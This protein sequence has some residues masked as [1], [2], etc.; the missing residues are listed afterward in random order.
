MPSAPTERPAAA[1]PPPA[2]RAPAAPFDTHA[3]LRFVVN[4]MSGRND[5][6]AKQEVI[7]NAL[8]EAGRAGELLLAPPAE[9]ARVA[10]RA[11]AAAAADGGAVV[12]VGGDGTINAVAQAAHA[13][14]CAM[15]VLPQGTFNYFARTHGIPSDPAEAARA[16]FGWRPQPVQLGLVNGHRFLV[17][18][19]LGLYPE[20]L[21]DREAW[22]ARFGRSRIVAL[23]AAIATVVGARRRLRL[24]IDAGGRA[25]EVRT[26]TLFV[27]NNRLQLEQ[28][29]LAQAPALDAGH[30][31]AVT[32]RPIGT[33]AMFGLM[34]RGAL[35]TLGEADTVESFEFHH[36]TVQPWRRR[37][38]G[39]KV[40]CDGEVRWMRPPLEFSVAPAPLWLLKPGP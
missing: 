21:E 4:A 40:A 28:V 23:G 6:A 18:A 24:H 12:A 25:R 33:L 31:V 37:R 29:G 10:D 9:L 20:L 11:A 3:P 17:N 16:L 19:S 36:M 1:T 38:R 14:G 15:G 39:V 27:G 32:L 26:Q 13:H 7:E 5:A 2:E 30:I 34:L 22:K 35:G 8:R